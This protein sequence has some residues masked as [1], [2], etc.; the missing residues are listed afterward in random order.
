MRYKNILLVALLVFIFITIFFLIQQ[1]PRVATGNVDPFSV[2][3]STTTPQVA[4]LA[5]LCSDTTGRPISGVFG[6]VHV[7]T[8]GTGSMVFYDATTTNVN[9]RTGNRATSTLILAEYREG[10]AT[11][12]NAFN[13]RF[14]HGL[15]ID[16]SAGV[17][18]ST[19]TYRCGG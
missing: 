18:T 8:S 6:S 19:I 16:Y 17:A 4:D 14:N 1:E 15:L 2:L 9:L 5:N 12:S 10:F 11:T 13:S 7:L 3:D